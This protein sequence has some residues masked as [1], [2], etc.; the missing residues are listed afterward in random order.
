M[1]FSY[2]SI[3]VPKNNQMEQVKK[4]TYYD[5][6]YQALVLMKLNIDSK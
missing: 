4:T 1:S 3:Q 2:F 5:E 6:K